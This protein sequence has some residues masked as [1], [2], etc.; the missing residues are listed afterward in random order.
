MNFRLAILIARA[1]GNVALW[2]DATD[3]AVQA[4]VGSQGS[5]GIGRRALKTALM[6][7]SGALPPLIVALRMVRPR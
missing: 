3:V 5:F 4:N 7:H 1:T 6:T 2:P